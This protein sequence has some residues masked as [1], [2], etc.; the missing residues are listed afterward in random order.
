MS[1]AL[2]EDFAEIVSQGVQWYCVDPKSGD[3]QEYDKHTNAKIEKAY[4]K[5]ERSVIFLVNNEKCE[6]VFDKMQETNLCN[7]ETIK[8]M[9]KD[10]KGI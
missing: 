7:N 10:L 1:T 4:S 9:R 5:Q 8:V 2:Q 6:T 3:Q